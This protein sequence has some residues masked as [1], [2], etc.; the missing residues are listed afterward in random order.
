MSSNSREFLKSRKCP[1]ILDG[2]SSFVYKATVSE[3]KVPPESQEWSSSVDQEAPRIK[4]EQEE[5]W[6]SQEDLTKFPFT[7][8]PLKS[9]DE[10]EKPPSLLLQ[11]T[12]H[13]E[14]DGEDC[15]GPEPARNSD[16]HPDPYDK[17]GNSSELKT[18]VSETREPGL[19]AQKN[20][21]RITGK[22]SFRCSECGKQFSQNSNLKTHMRIHTGEKPF[23]C[24]VCG[25]RFI[26]KVH[27]TY[28]MARHTGDKLYHCSVCDQ[29]FTWLY[30]LKNHTCIYQQSVLL[31]Q[32]VENKEDHGGPGATR[33][34]DPGGHFHLR[35]G[36]KNS[37]TKTVE[38]D[39]GMSNGKI[40]FRCSDC[41]QTFGRKTLLWEHMK[42]HT[43]EK[44]FSCSVCK[45]NFPW[46]KHLQRHM[47][48][49]MEEKKLS[50]SVCSKKFNWAYQLNL[51]QCVGE[52][53]QH[54]ANQ[55]HNQSGS[56]T[57]EVPVRETG[58]PKKKTFPCPHCSKIFGYKDS[59]LRH[60]RCHTGEKPFSCS[61]CGRRFRERGNLG[62]HMVVHTREKPFRCVVCGQGFSWRKQLKKHKCDGN[63]SSGR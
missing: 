63:S 2:S 40:A 34:S 61:V 4:E 15:G 11:Q 6:S 5:L 52:S 38:S 59:L 17:T 30:Q 53:S 22:R 13:M 16:P 48:I 29:G 54:G 8:V 12:E 36:G 45:K 14:A 26:Q 10:E 7:A 44:L 57:Q 21:K 23:S 20:N 37:A 55:T 50:C 49:H 24:L 43:G 31:N 9:E 51:H 46:R 18:L 56:N 41:G 3:E 47:R 60:I 19:V 58:H 27:L 25:K 1:V 35:T 42:S 62:Q 28:H 33:N 32:T 39:T